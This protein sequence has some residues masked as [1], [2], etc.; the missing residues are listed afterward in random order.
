MTTNTPEPVEPKVILCGMCGLNEMVSK[1]DYDAMKYALL[2]TLLS[3][4]PALQA[5]RERTEKAE[6]DAKH[7]H[8]KCEMLQ[9]A[10]YE[11]EEK[12]EAELS[13]LEVKTWN[14]AIEAAA[15]GFELD[16]GHYYDQ[17]RES[18]LRLKK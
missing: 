12:A 16:D 14:A 7:Y 4:L 13:A 2:E 9:T 18:I 10:M 11:A 1:A 8:Q 15:E 3:T 5:E 6:A 17:V